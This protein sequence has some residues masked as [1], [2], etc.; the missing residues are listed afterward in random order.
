[1]LTHLDFRDGSLLAIYELAPSF[2]LRFLTAIGS[3]KPVRR[4]TADGREMVVNPAWPCWHRNQRCQMKDKRLLICAHRYLGM[5]TSSW[6]PNRTVV[7]NSNKH[8]QCV[9][10][11]LELQSQGKAAQM[12]SQISPLLETGSPARSTEER[13]HL[14]TTC[15]PVSVAGCVPVRPHVRY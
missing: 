11:S 3:L 13:I 15:V 2:S 1:M 9:A 7:R 14:M 6:M 8:L 4:A 5:L 10:C 12:F